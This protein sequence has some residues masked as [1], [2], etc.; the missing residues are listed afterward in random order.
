MYVLCCSSVSS[1]ESVRD[2]YFRR[3]NSSKRA[4]LSTM[5]LVHQF[6]VSPVPQIVIFHSSLIK[7]VPTSSQ[8]PGFPFLIPASCLHYIS[9]L[10]ISLMSCAQKDPEL[11]AFTDVSWPPWISTP[12]EAEAPPTN[13][14]GENGGDEN[15]ATRK[16]VGEKRKLVRTGQ[17]DKGLVRKGVGA[18]AGNETATRK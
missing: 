3:D 15:G 9:L 13:S 4:M 17:R 18:A 11:T 8:R 12:R 5:F 7:F 6:T 16:G 1:M 10:R 2:S 14:G